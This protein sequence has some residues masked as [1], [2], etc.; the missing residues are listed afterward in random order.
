MK[1]KKRAIIARRRRAEKNFEVYG[2]PTVPPHCPHAIPDTVRLSAG[3]AGSHPKGG[4]PL[5]Q[6]DHRGT[7]R[8]PLLDF[9]PKTGGPPLDL[10]GGP[11]LTLGSQF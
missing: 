6:N 9:G 4:P 3:S 1:S 11:P 2:A 7:L 8:P 5:L 10:G